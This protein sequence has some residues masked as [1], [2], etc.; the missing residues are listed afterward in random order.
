MHRQPTS[1]FYTRQ[2]PC[3][4][5]WPPCNW[6]PNQ[7]TSLLVRNSVSQPLSLSTRKPWLQP[8][9]A[10]A[11]HLI[12][13]P[14][15]QNASHNT[16]SPPFLLTCLHCSLWQPPTSHPPSQAADAPVH[17]SPLRPLHVKKGQA[18]QKCLATLRRFL[19]GTGGVNW[20]HLCIYCQGGEGGES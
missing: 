16:F 18:C 20:P 10:T 2:E 13:Q 8:T 15:A 17:P 3:Q 4:P 19:W 14:D 9:N 6:P 1:Q 5:S 12:S 11:S 7:Q